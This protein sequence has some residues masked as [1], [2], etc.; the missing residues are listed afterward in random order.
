[1]SAVSASGH[2]FGKVAVLFGG[3]SAEREVSLKSGA[4]VLA[5]LQR[6][7]V[8]AHAFDPAV[9]S[10]EALRDEGFERVFIAGMLATMIEAEKFGLSYDV[11]DDLTGKKLGRASSGTFRTA[12]V[13]GLDTLAHTFKTMDDNLPDDPWHKYYAVPAYVK[14]MIEKGALGQK[15]KA[16]FFTKKGKDILV[17][18]LAKQDYVTGTGK[19]VYQQAGKRHGMIKRTKKQIRNL[20][21]TNVLFKTDGDNIKKYWMPNG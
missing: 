10:L 1:M 15:T 4:A 5:A 18:D 6:S 3:S 21:G 12:D 19:V 14:A 2:N 20:R 7:G 16:G 17:L 9:R 11:V 8:D 13:V